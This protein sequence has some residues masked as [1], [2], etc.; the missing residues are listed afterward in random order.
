[1]PTF[2]LDAAMKDGIDIPTIA[3]KLADIHK[4]D[5]N[6]ARSEGVTDEQIVAKLKDIDVV[7]VVKTDKAGAVKDVANLFCNF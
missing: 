6:W 1:M 3:E 5:R 7:P 4:F 2:D